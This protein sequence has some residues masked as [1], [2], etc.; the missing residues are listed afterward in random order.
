MG[1]F[2]PALSVAPRII[3]A[4]A[5]PPAVA[6]KLRRVLSIRNSFPLAQTPASVWPT[7]RKR[8]LCIIG[9]AV[10]SCQDAP[11]GYRKRLLMYKAILFD[12]G[13]VLIPFDFR[14][15]YRKG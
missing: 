10:R 13:K 12:L 15:G 6:K 8:S 14:R 3:G 2:V 1:F 11:A 9:R 5:R 7:A 4:A